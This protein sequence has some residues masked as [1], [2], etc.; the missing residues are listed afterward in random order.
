[1]VVLLEKAYADDFREKAA[2]S[3]ADIEEMYAQIIK[4]NPNPSPWMQA[5][6]DDLADTIQIG[7][8]ISTMPAAEF[9]AKYPDYLND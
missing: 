8:D 7:K 5:Y 3:L 9:E 1:M 2:K 6:I 4:D